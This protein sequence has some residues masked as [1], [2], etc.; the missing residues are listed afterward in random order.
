MPTVPAMSLQKHAG[1]LTWVLVL[2]TGHLLKLSLLS[3]LKSSGLFSSSSA[4]PQQPLF[5]DLSYKL[6]S[7]FKVNCGMR[8]ALFLF[9]A[10]VYQCT[11]SASCAPGQSSN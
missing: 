1:K 10:D 5:C 3:Y 7:F 8:A 4:V 6:T 11:S 9:V 2:I